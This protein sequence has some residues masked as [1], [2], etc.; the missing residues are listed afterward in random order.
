MFSICQVQEVSLQNGITLDALRN[1]T[2]EVN[3]ITLAIHPAVVEELH[4]TSEQ[5]YELRQIRESYK[6]ELLSRMQELY[7]DQPG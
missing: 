7:A 2:R 6:L 3:P 1:N 5:E 4:L